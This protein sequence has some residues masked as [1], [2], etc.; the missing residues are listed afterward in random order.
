MLKAYNISVEI[1]KKKILTDVSF[2]L[3]K[4]DFLMV[5]GPNGSGKT[6]LVKAIMNSINHTGDAILM[7][8]SIK[9][10]GNLELAQ[11]IGVLTQNHAIQFSYKVHEVVKLGRYAHQKGLFNQFTK[12][13]EEAV[14]KAMEVTGV[15]DIK[16][17]DIT[18]L[19]G[20][21]VQRVFLAQLF[22]QDAKVLILDEP[23]NHLDLQYQLG[24]F[25]IISKWVKIGDRAVIS[26]VHDL[27]MVYTY[28]TRALMLSDGKVYA[29]GD[30]ESVLNKANLKA[31]YKVDVADWMKSLLS[32]W[33]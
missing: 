17:Q 20:G 21:E 27:N 4:N 32:H 3:K 12:E 9:K 13:D 6:T 18:T 14:N 1:D 33:E 19:S 2:E 25:D 7:S 11:N 31:V 8:K 15:I 30:V 10:Y 26:I 28:G 23:T 29:Y 5:I 16:E 22:A 24:I